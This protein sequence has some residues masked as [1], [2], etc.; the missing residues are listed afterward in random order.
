VQQVLVVAG[1]DLGKP[2]AGQFLI[3][4]QATHVL[5][6]VARDE[7][8]SQRVLAVFPATVHR[9]QASVRAQALGSQFKEAAGCLVVQM[10]QQADGYDAIELAQVQ[11]SVCA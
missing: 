8:A 6:A 9:D 3:A 2:T 5:A 1:H 10:V 7:P 11:P 4:L